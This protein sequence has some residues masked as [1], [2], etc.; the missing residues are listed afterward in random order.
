MRLFQVKIQISCADKNNC[1]ESIKSDDLSDLLNEAKS[2]IL[3]LQQETNSLKSEID[4]MRQ[5]NQEYCKQIETLQN[6]V[7]MNTTLVHDTISVNQLPIPLEPTVIV[8]ENPIQNNSKS[9][10]NLDSKH[11][12]NRLNDTA[13]YGINLNE[14][15]LA[16]E[17]SSSDNTY[18]V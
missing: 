13:N 16:S 12:Q 8:K 11:Q 2:T 14:N 4:M 1:N 18:L 5:Q 15:S 9:I 10:H 6:Q 3:K 7:K 17:Q